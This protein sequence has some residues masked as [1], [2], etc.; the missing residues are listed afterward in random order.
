M[1]EGSQNLVQSD[2]ERGWAKIWSGMHGFPKFLNF[3]PNTPESRLPKFVTDPPLKVVYGEKLFPLLRIS[4][5]LIFQTAK[6]LH[7]RRKVTVSFLLC[8]TSNFREFGLSIFGQTRIHLWCV[9]SL[10]K[11]KLRPI[12]RS[13]RQRHLA[14]TSGD[15]VTTNVS[16][17]VWKTGTTLIVIPELSVTI[18]NETEPFRNWSQ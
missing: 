13:S 10:Q 14:K 4:A 1:G 12:V 18:H 3:F 2:G 17:V 9:V 7:S 15:K 16:L 8:R 11:V 5:S 6:Q